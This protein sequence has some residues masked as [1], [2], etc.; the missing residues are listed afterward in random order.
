MIVNDI[1]RVV[2][3]IFKSISLIKY[4]DM[5]KDNEDKMMEGI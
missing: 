1:A 2:K 3:S 5:I 4:S